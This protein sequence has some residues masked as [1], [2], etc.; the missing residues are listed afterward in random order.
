[1]AMKRLIPLGVVVSTLFASVAFTADNPITSG[2]Q[3][4][5]DVADGIIGSWVLNREKSDDP[6]E[7]MQESQQEGAGGG[8]RSGGGGGGR[9]RGGAGGRTSGGRTGGRDDNVSM[10]RRQG[11]QAF[12]RDAMRTAPRIQISRTDSTVTLETPPQ[13]SRILFTDNR[14][15]TTP[16]T[17]DLEQKLKSKWD[18]DKLVIETQADAGIKAKF[19]Y[20]RDKE[21]LKIKVRIQI[22][23]PRQVIRYELVYDPAD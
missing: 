13:G 16:I 23:R 5:V 17:A 12:M 19:E 10:E 15:V 7:V 22:S 21:Q 2:M 11:M 18:G 14:E 1:M 9:Q 4:R 20:E 8:M 6:R 3:P